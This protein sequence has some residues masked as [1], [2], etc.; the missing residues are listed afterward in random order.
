MF[1]CLTTILCLAI[2]TFFTGSWCQFAEGVP[3]PTVIFSENFD[4]GLPGSG[5]V[6]GGVG[7][8]TGTG[9]AARLSNGGNN[10]DYYTSASFGGELFTVEADV[11]QINGNAGGTA[12]GL[13]IGNRA[14]VFFG[15]HPGGAFN[16]LQVDPASAT[17]TGTTL[18]NTN[19]GYTPA[20]GT[21]QHFEIDVDPF[22]NLF[23]ITV[24]N[25]GGP[26]TFN[27][28]QL[29]PGF[30]AGGVGFFNWSDPHVADYDNLE[31]IA[32]REPPEAAAVPEPATWMLLLSGLPALMRALGRRHM[33]AA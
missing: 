27:W 11:N 19:M 9:G 17:V 2:P 8:V 12:N 28:T 10:F 15:D 26:G 22:L 29:D 25:T 3:V 24:T 16:I 31:V 4:G 14:F 32:L 23:N 7:V 30:V 1:R 21:T 18:G 13:L 33:S 20:Q 5:F 6:T